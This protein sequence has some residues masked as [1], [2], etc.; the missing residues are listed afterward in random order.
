M[1]DTGL[2]QTTLSTPFEPGT[3]VK[4]HVTGANWLFLL[5]R[6]SFG[7]VACVGTPPEATL[8]ALA[9]A[10]REVFVLCPTQSEARAARSRVQRAGLSQVK[11]LAPR[12]GEPVA[13]PATELD[14]VYVASGAA[15]RWLNR[16]PDAAKG[17]ARALGPDG[18]I[19]GETWRAARQDG[20]PVPLQASGV[21]RRFRLSPPLGEMRAA[22]PA[23]DK[24]TAQFFRDHDLDSTVSQRVQVAALERR[25]T[26]RLALDHLARRQ[27]L[28]VDRAGSHHA[29]PPAWLR[30][31]ADQ[32]GV[33]IGPCRWG[34]VASGL[35]ASRKVLVYLF[36]PGQDTLRYVAKLTRAPAFNARLENE[37]RALAL[38]ADR[39]LAETGVMPRPAFFGHHAGL[40][41]LGQTAVAG[42]PFA[43]RSQLTADCPFGRAAVGWLEDLG[44]ATADP[45][46]AAPSEVAAVLGELRDRF[47]AL[48]GLTAHQR[49][50]VDAAIDA[51]GR[52]HG[53]LPLVFQH[54][55]PGAWN[56]LALPD[57]RVGFVDW[58][59][60]EVRGLPLWDLLY[61]L[62]SYCVRSARRRGQRDRLVAATRPILQSSDPLHALVQQSVARY[63]DRVGLAPEHVAPLFLTCWL[64]RALKEA[65]RLT[66]ERL[67]G[68]HYACLV[69]HYA[70]AWPTPGLDW[71]RAGGGPA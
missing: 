59:A 69:R 11:L 43:A 41:V 38:L 36:D 30:G 21:T 42:A 57:G 64:H 2:L 31:I 9:Q 7:A 45:A 28:L 8:R 22:V 39:G 67:Q 46:A 20:L 56:A 35:Y 50:V 58:E 29:G 18:L 19:Y 17:L 5:P 48:Y 51:V 6:L 53:P 70:D 37:H 14:L 65:N 25:L 1:S 34:L 61:F 16:H 13:P 47:V 40:A 33:D 63:R 54:G 12:P 4:G 62:R 23:H 32:S 10:C 55:D 26:R 24:S 3:N 49:G 68:G 52:S 15:A 71:L 44:A 66:P 27:G 60:A